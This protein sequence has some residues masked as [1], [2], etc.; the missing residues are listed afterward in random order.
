MG[1][2]FGVG[3]SESATKIHVSKFP[4]PSFILFNKSNVF[5][6]N[7]QFDEMYNAYSSYLKFHKFHVSA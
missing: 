6:A 2:Q 5:E 3:E 7:V 1:T 4:F